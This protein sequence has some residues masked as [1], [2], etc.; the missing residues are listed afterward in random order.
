M[1]R[2]AFFSLAYVQLVFIIHETMWN[3][4]LPESEQT[5]NL[6]RFFAAVTV[7]YMKPRYISLATFA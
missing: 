6:V 7:V 3:S 2:P 5:N 4:K 1:T